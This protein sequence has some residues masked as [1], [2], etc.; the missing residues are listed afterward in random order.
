MTENT[1]PNASNLEAKPAEAES[2][3][4]K[5]SKWVKQVA[6]TVGALTA[7]VTTAFTIDSRYVHAGELEKE[8]LKQQQLI[9]ELRHSTL[10]DKV[11]ELELR[12][13]SQPKTWTSTDQLMLNRYKAKLKQISDIKTK[14]DADLRIQTPQ[15]KTK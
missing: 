1:S 5:G 14:Q 15:E 8:S 10:D 11:F 13:A 6:A 2:L 7:L 4:S 3:P 12:K 9:T